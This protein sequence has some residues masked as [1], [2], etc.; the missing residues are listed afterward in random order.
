LQQDAVIHLYEV[1]FN[2]TTDLKRDHPDL[3][4]VREL[5]NDA[6]GHPTKRGN[7]SSFHYIGRKS[8]TTDSLR[9]I[10]R[11][12][13]SNK[14]EFRDFD[15]K[16]IKMKQEKDVNKILDN[17][18]EV[19][20]KEYNN[21]KR[22][23]KNSTLSGLI[24]DSMG[25]MIGKDYEGIYN[26]YPLAEMNFSIIKETIETIKNENI[27]RYGSI[28]ALQG[29]EDVL[30]RIDYIV[31]RVE[32]WIQ[33]SELYKNFDAEVFLDSFYDRFKELEVMLKE[34]DEEFSKIN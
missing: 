3:Y 19:M 16:E 5:R 6:I 10:S 22:K 15:I 31:Q 30:R 27:K 34:I 8:V 18:I 4:F 13:K 23:F 26:N 11:Y 21:H 32:K 33:D 14:T 28:S 1:L 9:L 7:D 29:I 25:Y 24:P 12:P 2:K 17:V 20:E